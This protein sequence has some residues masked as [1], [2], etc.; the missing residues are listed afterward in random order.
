MLYYIAAF[1]PVEE[2]GYAVRVPDIPEVA[3]QGDD[4]AEAMDMARDAVAVSLEAYV[5]EKRELPTPSGMDE[6]R[7]KVMREDRELGWETPSDTLYQL[8]PAPDLDRT[9]VKVTLSMPRNV[10]SLLDR[11][12]E[13]AGMTR[14]GY[15]ARLASIM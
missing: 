6:A 12:A 9:P 11:K 14:S 7:E 1:E 3:T 10:L 4:L 8:V 2:G 13:L 5:R 15:V